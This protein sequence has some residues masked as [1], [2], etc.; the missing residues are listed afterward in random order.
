MGMVVNVICCQIQA[1]KH[2]VSC[3]TPLQLRN[4]SSVPSKILMLTTVNNIFNK[5]LCHRVKQ[6]CDIIGPVLAGQLGRGALERQFDGPRFEPQ[7]IFSYSI[8][9]GGSVWILKRACEHEMV[10]IQISADQRSRWCVRLVVRRSRVR[11]PVSFNSFSPKFLRSSHILIKTAVSI[12]NKPL[13]TQL[14][15]QK[16]YKFKN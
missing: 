12:I 9:F 8:T 7:Y 13:P 3:T 16:K 10:W 6:R 2:R 1:I 14:T 4:K 15:V 11:A 5:T